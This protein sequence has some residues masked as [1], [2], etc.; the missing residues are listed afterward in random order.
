MSSNAEIE[1][2]I[3]LDIPGFLDS[4]LYSVVDDYGLAGQEINSYLRESKR[5]ER[6]RL[7]MIGDMFVADGIWTTEQT[8]EVACSVENINNSM[9]ASSNLAGHFESAS[10][11][12]KV[13]SYTISKELVGVLPDQIH[14]EAGLAINP[15]SKKPDFIIEL[16]SYTR[17]SKTK[18][19]SILELWILSH[20]RL[21]S[22]YFIQ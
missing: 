12:H 19:F 13:Y 4:E 6:F 1:S 22:N 11:S 14:L 2:K 18:G 15:K 20:P 9:F 16:I 10:H 3:F 5:P 21:D 8:I 17:E 7:L